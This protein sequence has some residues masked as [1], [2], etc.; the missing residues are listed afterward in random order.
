MR[1]SLRAFWI[2][3]KTWCPS[4]TSRIY[5]NSYRTYITTKRNSKRRKRKEGR[6][7]LNNSSKKRRSMMT[8]LK[9]TYKDCLPTSPRTPD[10]LT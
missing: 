4:S 6:R 8:S 10:C 7:S 9:K 1:T 3:A 5:K 2:Q